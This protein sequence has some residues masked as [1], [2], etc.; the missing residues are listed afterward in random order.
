VMDFNVVRRPAELTGVS[1]QPFH[2][3]TRP[4]QIGFVGAS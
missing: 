3:F 1:Q 2:D 4:L